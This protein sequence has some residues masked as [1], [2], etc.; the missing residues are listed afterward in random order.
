MKITFRISIFIIS[1]IG[2]AG[3]GSIERSPIGT[4]A[5][6]YSGPR[7]PLSQ[8][9]VLSSTGGTILRIDGEKI[10]SFVGH[11]TFELLPGPHSIDV[12]YFRQHLKNKTSYSKTV[13]TISTGPI[14]LSFNSKPGFNYTIMHFYYY[15]NTNNIYSMK[16]GKISKDKAYPKAIE[17]KNKLSINWEPTFDDVKVMPYVREQ[18]EGKFTLVKYLDT[19][20]ETNFNH[21]NTI[22]NTQNRQAHECIGENANNY[23]QSIYL[24][25]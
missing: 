8:I 9:S 15:S 10:S 6:M 3:C 13:G 7:L 22:V 11:K 5:R 19:E 21:I 17:C 18:G 20:F 4:Q 24:F 12:S 14:R 16:Y 1:F 23:F 25:Q 2:I